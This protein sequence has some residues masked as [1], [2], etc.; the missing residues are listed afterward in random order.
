MVL[1]G[2][3]RAPQALLC[4]DGCAW[5]PLTTDR[6]I[7]WIYGFTARPSTYA[8]IARCVY[9]AD[10]W[11]P[12]EADCQKMWLLATSLPALFRRGKGLGLHASIM[13]TSRSLPR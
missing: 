4:I 2:V 8:L 10:W 13:S 7:R 5:H 12:T 6:W 1:T 11:T 3:L 9:L